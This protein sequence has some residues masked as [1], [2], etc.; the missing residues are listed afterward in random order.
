MNNLPEINLP[1][2]EF[3]NDEFI[4]CFIKGFKILGTLEVDSLVSVK[5]VFVVK[6]QQLQYSLIII[7]Q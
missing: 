1:H 6:I 2:N 7:I 3:T 5:V 4:R